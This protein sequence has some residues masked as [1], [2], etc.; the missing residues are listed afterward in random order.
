[1]HAWLQDLP[2]A[3]RKQLPGQQRRPALLIPIGRPL[4][5]G[6]RIECEVGQSSAGSPEMR[7]GLE[8]F[9][10]RPRG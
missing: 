5:E 6:L 2:R 10:N 1:M 4:E 3:E 8:A 9:R 7:A